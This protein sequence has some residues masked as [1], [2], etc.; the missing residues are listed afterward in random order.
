MLHQ[1]KAAMAAAAAGACRSIRSVAST[2]PSSSLS[3]RIYFMDHPPLHT[4]R[5][6]SM[7]SSSSSSN[8]WLP[9]ALVAVATASVLT[10]LTEAA[11]PTAAASA[12]DS[13]DDTKDNSKENVLPMRE[14]MAL[15]ESRLKP[16]R[17][18]RFLS[19]RPRRS[20]RSGSGTFPPTVGEHDLPTVASKTFPKIAVLSKGKGVDEPYTI[21]VPLPPTASRETNVLAACLHALQKKGHTLTFHTGLTTNNG[22]SLSFVFGDQ[23]GSVLLTSSSAVAAPSSSTE[24]MPSTGTGKSS[25]LLYKT[26]GFTEADVDA[27]VDSYIMAWRSSPD[28]QLTG[29]FL[30]N[31]TDVLDALRIG[32]GG[33]GKYA[34]DHEQDVPYSSPQRPV[35]PHSP[36]SRP[37]S[38]RGESI[39]ERG[40]GIGSGQNGTAVMGENDPVSRLKKLGAE[41]F[42]KATEEELDWTCLAGYESIKAE[43]EDT[44]VMALQ[45]AEA[46]DAIARQTRERYESNRPRAVLFEGP[47]GTG[48]TL[49]AR[50]IASRTEVPLV[51]I[52]TERV[53]SKWYGDSEKNLAKVFEACKELGGAI[54]FI[55]EVDA[56][57]ASRDTNMHEATRRLLSVILQSIEGFRGRNKN[58]LICATNRK[59]DLDSALLSRFDVSIKFD[60]PTCPARQAIFARY[61]K[62]LAGN[63]LARLAE[64]SEAYSCRDIKEV[65]ENTERKWASKTIRGQADGLTPPLKEYLNQL[66]AQTLSDHQTLPHNV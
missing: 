38:T 17:T 66:K 25:L 44:V 12:P 1:R 39:V 3:T 19:S 21:E 36:F 27:V 55:D 28:D 31:F 18:E 4:A 34:F 32:G 64:A 7:A 53:L 6:A 57:A 9:A 24:V 42:E 20:S 61:A 26:K 11:P 62:H 15:I 41:V 23:S 14:V 43:V 48:K 8:A 5:P 63:E 52:S 22:T 40:G 37:S 35:P 60:L 16:F 46:Y 54:I 33:G 58:V 59:Q 51:F 45:H 29:S 50:I 49:T 10:S 65:C 13:S 30:S 47:P 56:L 2:L